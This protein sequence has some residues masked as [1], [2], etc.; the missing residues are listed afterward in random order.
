[1]NKENSI[2]LLNETFNYDF[3]INNYIK[4]INELFNKFTVNVKS[5]TVWEN[6]QIILNLIK[7]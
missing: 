4:F 6:I 2:K 5:E 7:F 3:N 1:M